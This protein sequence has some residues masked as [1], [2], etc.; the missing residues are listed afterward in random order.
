MSAQC[1]GE[2]KRNPD[3]NKHDQQ[4]TTKHKT[5]NNKNDKQKNDENKND[6]RKPFP[7]SSTSA[8]LQPY[9]SPTSALLQP[10]FSPTSAL[11]GPCTSSCLAFGLP[12]WRHDCTGIGCSGVRLF[13]WFFVPPRPFSKNHCC[14][15]GRVKDSSTKIEKVEKIE[16]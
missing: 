4:I 5:T 13:G 1:G 11:L 16:K 15:K 12:S 10:Y 2:A 9:F 14:K 6:E 3:G 7:S 8:L